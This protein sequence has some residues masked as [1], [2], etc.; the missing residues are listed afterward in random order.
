MHPSPSR[1]QS[2]HPIQARNVQPG[3]A[4]KI[5]VEIFV[6][7]AQWGS[8]H[9]IRKWPGGIF[10]DVSTLTSRSDIER[11]NFTLKTQRKQDEVEG[12]VERGDMAIFEFMIQTFDERIKERKKAGDARFSILLEPHFEQQGGAVGAEVSRDSESDGK[13]W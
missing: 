9:T 1:S 5:G 8:G 10:D 6:I 12:L 7:I 4:I 13:D 3:P 2:G 11:I